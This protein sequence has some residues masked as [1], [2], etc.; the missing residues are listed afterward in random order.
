M[1]PAEAESAQ[2]ANGAVLVDMGSTCLLYHAF[3]LYS[4]EERLILQP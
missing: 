2:K 4:A 3:E 1:L